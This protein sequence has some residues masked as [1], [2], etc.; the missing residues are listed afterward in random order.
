MIANRK[1]LVIA[2]DLDGT[3]IDHTRNK[4]VLAERFGYRLDAASTR[5]D[6][7]KEIIAEQ[8][9]RHIQQELYGKA[10]LSA[11]PVQFAKEELAVLK[12]MFGP[13]YIISRRLGHTRKYGMQWLARH[14]GDIIAPEDVFFVDEESEKDRIARRLGIDVYIDD[15]AS[16]LELMRSVGRKYFF[17]PFSDTEI[18]SDSMVSVRTWRDFSRDVQA[19]ARHAL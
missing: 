14:C 1:K 16:V 5:S 17:D 10:T 4:I 7:M 13:V 19:F 9:Y 2:S 6:R 8:D 15:K 11:P 3:I 12:K 18:I